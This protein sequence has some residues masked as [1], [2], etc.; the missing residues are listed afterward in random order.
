MA[1]LEDVVNT[2][3]DQ[4]KNGSIQWQPNNWDDDGTPRRWITSDP[5]PGCEFDLMG[6]SATLNMLHERRWITLGSGTHVNRLVD[7]VASTA[8]RKGTTRDEALQKALSCLTND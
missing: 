3:I 6:K 7:T 2:L 8:N 5:N 4:T 1:T